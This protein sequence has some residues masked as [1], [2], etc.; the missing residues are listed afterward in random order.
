MIFAGY[1][2]KMEKFLNVNP[3]LRSRIYRKFTFP[4]YSTDEL[5]EIFS[6]KGQTRGIPGGWQCG[7]ISCCIHVTC[8]KRKYECTPG[9]NLDH[10]SVEEA[11][12]ANRIEGRRHSCSLLSSSLSSRRRFFFLNTI[13]PRKIALPIRAPP[14]LPLPFR[15]FHMVFTILMV[16]NHL[17][18][19]FVLVRFR[20]NTYGIVYR[21]RY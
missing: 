9:T 3:G 13:F 17:K 1:E 16:F 6:S 11:S 19:D 2:D 14:I 4:D 12:T 15:C 8:P 18:S 7:G 20:D 10:K 21:K 5:G